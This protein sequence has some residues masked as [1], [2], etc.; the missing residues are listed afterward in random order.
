MNFMLVIGYSFLV[1][2]IAFAFIISYCYSFCLKN[3]ANHGYCYQ[4]Y[5]RKSDIGN[6]VIL[7][8]KRV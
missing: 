8:F 2:V 1:I 5:G 6:T 3:G 4:N 7:V